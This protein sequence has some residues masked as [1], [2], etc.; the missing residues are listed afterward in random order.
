MKNVI[1]GMLILLVSRSPV[2]CQQ[3]LTPK[4]FDSLLIEV[5]KFMISEKSFQEVIDW[6]KVML[7]KAKKQNY[8]KGIAWAHINL[9]N[10]YCTRG[11][12]ELSIKHLN[13]V[14][15][16]VKDRSLSDSHTIAKMYQE[17]SQNY[18]TMNL[19]ELAL[20]NNTK[21]I[22]YGK[23]IIDDDESCFVSDR[24]LQYAC[25]CRAN[26]FYEL[27]ELDSAVLYLHRSNHHYETPLGFAAIGNHYT[28]YDFSPDS[29]KIY[30]DKAIHLVENQAKN[31]TPYNSSVIYFYYGNY[32]IKQRDYQQAT[33][34]LEMS[35]SLAEEA[36]NVGHLENVYRTL[37]E[38]YKE[39][40]NVENEKENLAKYALL[41]DNTQF[42]Q[43]KG[44][45]LSIRTMEK[46]KNEQTKGVKKT[47]I[48]YTSLILVIGGFIVCYFYFENKKKKQKIIEKEKLIAKKEEETKTLQRKLSTAHEEVIQ[49]AKSNDISFLVRFQE[50]YPSVSQKLWE[51]NPNLT[52]ADLSFCA[53]IWLGFSSKD[54][55]Q[56]TFM[57]HRSVQIKKNRLRKKL[58]LG[59]HVDLYHFLKS[60][61]D[62]EYT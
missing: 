55:A 60:L 53:L 20:E 17:Y 26:I 49:L 31:V 37:A 19:Y 29:A 61:S 35:R 11:E 25:S 52:H 28:D 23:K 56:Y 30:L 48:L 46:E 4:Q 43:A 22:F 3:E 38:T 7:E 39:L 50:V 62:I 57:Q 41:K 1:F 40:G 18:Y 34:Y 33:H 14:N 27:N 12:L 54:I 47:A 9:A 58:N 59:S 8:P 16:M 15:K 42:S 32:Y 36:G 13:A 51:I 45:E 44:V 24:F 6:N 5:N 2:F 10:R 21:A